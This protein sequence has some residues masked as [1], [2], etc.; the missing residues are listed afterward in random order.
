[1][2]NY[3]RIK[4]MSAE[5]MARWMLDGVSSEPCDYCRHNSYECE[6]GY[7]CDEPDDVKTLV[8]WLTADTDEIIDCY[9]G[10]EGD[11]PCGQG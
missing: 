1:M 4:G 3:E 6:M 10:K 9:S 7:G 8:D 2:T 5:E 11:N